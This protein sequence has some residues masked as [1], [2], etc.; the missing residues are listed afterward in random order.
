M[1]SEGEVTESMMA[2]TENINIAKISGFFHLKGLHLV[3][4]VTFSAK[5]CEMGRWGH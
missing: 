3:T 2:Q 4:Y 1:C 5:Y